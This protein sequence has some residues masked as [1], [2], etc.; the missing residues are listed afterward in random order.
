MKGGLF[1]DG[2]RARAARHEDLS[3]S[4]FKGPQGLLVDLR[5]SRSETAQNWTRVPGKAPQDADSNPQ[6]RL[7]RHLLRGLVLEVPD[8]VSMG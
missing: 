6:K 7:G 5:E 8:A 4:V 2:R 3:D 1:F